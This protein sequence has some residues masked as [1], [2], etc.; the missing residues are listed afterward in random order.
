MTAKTE[1]AEKT[2]TAAPQ[3]AES[4]GAVAVLAP[5]RLP[6]HPAIEERFGIDRAAWKA[7]VESVWP[8]AKTSDAVALALSYCRARKLDPFKKPVHIVPMWNSALRR[9][10]ETV[11]PGIS[12]H[13]TTA[14]RTGQY[15]GADPTEFGPTIEI[16]FRDKDRSGADVGP[17]KVRFPEWAQITVYRMLQGQR[18]AFPGPRTLWEEFYS[19][20]KGTKVP[21]ERW[22][23]APSQ[24]I[25]KCAEAAALR[26]AFPEELGNE[27]IAEEMEDKVTTVAH[28]TL[29]DEPRPTRAS[30]AAPP[31][32][33]DTPADE[34]AAAHREMDRQATGEIDTD[35]VDEE[36][37]HLLPPL[38]PE[39]GDR[40]G[41]LIDAR[42]KI[43]TMTAQDIATLAIDE[44]WP[45]VIKSEI[46]KAARKRSGELGAKE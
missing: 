30:V 24:M 1:A 3:P 4:K 40:N 14:F 20:R 44:A 11:W 2:T 7:L 39:D 37:P 41:W 43:G 10:V 27:P 17:V 18:I 33:T 5:P 35:P 22:C 23:R 26:K 16:E 25:E 45:P 13:R 38:P 36:A 34:A 32:E 28:H 29:P 42:T 19:G 21:N 15:A 12:E 46:A 8:L 6:Y 31:A 9:E